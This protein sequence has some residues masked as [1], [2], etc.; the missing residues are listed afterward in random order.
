MVKRDEFVD[1][2]GA[3]GIPLPGVA[4]ADIPK[5]ASRIFATGD[6]NSDGQLDRWSDADY[7]L[8][9]FDKNSKL[10]FYYFLLL[11][12]LPLILIPQLHN[13]QFPCF[14]AIM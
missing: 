6:K 8:H 7:I 11:V 4:R 2:F 13:V 12:Y 3:G 5:I 10:Q 14:H 1:S 9:A